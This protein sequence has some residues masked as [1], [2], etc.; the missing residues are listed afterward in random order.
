MHAVFECM[1]PRVGS[2]WFRGSTSITLLLFPWSDPQKWLFWCW[3]NYAPAKKNLLDMGQNLGSNGSHC[4][5]GIPCLNY[6][7]SL[8]IPYTDVYYLQNTCM[9]FKW[10]NNIYF[11]GKCSQI[12]HTRM[13]WDRPP[14][15][16]ISFCNSDMLHPSPSLLTLGRMRASCSDSWLQIF[17]VS[18]FR[19]LP[20]K[21]PRIHPFIPRHPWLSWHFALLPT[22]FLARPA[23]QNW[24]VMSCWRA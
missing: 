3:C 14:R 12:H 9:A 16:Y 18:I 19:L 8:E 23:G 22:S 2:I 7:T 20:G 17:D 21:L 5:F 24:S 10:L 4:Q 1:F 13:A 11:G 15:R 6:Q